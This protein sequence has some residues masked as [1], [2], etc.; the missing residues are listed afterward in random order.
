MDVRELTNV[1]DYQKILQTGFAANRLSKDWIEEVE[2]LIPSPVIQHPEPSQRNSFMVMHND[3]YAQDSFPTA[4]WQSKEPMNGAE[5]KVSLGFNKFISDSQPHYRASKYDSKIFLKEEIPQRST[6]SLIPY[7]DINNS[8]HKNARRKNSHR[9]YTNDSSGYTE[10]QQSN[11]LQR[12]DINT[13][14]LKAPQDDLRSWQ[15]QHQEELLHQHLETQ[16]LYDSTTSQT[17]HSMLEPVFGQLHFEETPSQWE[18][19]RRAADNIIKEKNMI[20]DKL[21]NRILELEEDYNVLETNFKQALRTK[22][23]EADLM[24]K[25]L[26]ELQH[27]TISMKEQMNE[28]SSKQMTEVDDLEMKLGACEHQLQQMRTELQTKDTL[29]SELQ[30]QLTE[31]TEKAK[32][33][34]AKFLECCNSHHDMKKKLDGLQHY[35]D[36]L[37]TLEESR[38]QAQ[39]LLSLKAERYSMNT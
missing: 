17:T 19:V 22:E 15:Q 3:P 20:I 14:Y 34:K 38:I 8:E 12:K 39:E 2:T 26:Q 30:T 29:T 35:F 33:W 37:P 4:A 18:P 25:K 21:K 10:N 31:K 32:A 23:D 16:A 36:E 6:H 5:T 27:K 1:P 9:P 7:V 11:Y 24:K 13:S 28:A